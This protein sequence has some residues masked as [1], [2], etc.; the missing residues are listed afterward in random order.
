MKKRKNSWR[1]VNN[2]KYVPFWIIQTFDYMEGDMPLYEKLSYLF[3]IKIFTYQIQHKNLNKK[4]LDLIYKKT[5]DLIYK[6]DALTILSV[7]TWSFI[8]ADRAPIEYHLKIW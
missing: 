2:W 5:L 7:T 8:P 3:K 6:E 4:T 1:N